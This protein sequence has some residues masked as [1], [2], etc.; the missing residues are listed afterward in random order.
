MTR[1]TA[2][3]MLGLIVAAGSGAG[4]YS[5]LNGR[6]YVFRFSEGQLQE[7]LAERLPF[8]RTY[9]LIVQVTFDEP[10]ITLEEGSDRITAGLDVVVGLPGSEGASGLRGSVD[11]SS[12]LRYGADT[13][14]FFLVDP[15]IQRVSVQG[16]PDQYSARVNDAVT[17]ALA[18]YYRVR[19]VYTLRTTDVRHATAKL[20]LKH[21]IVA[22]GQLVV[23]LGL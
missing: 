20:L 21:V 6:E 23:T 11:A 1:R 7:N 17:R 16:I 2:A 10:R 3:V 15:V 5:Y 9:V 13:G 19:P 18:E 12:A 14:Q 22:D 4:L 8:T